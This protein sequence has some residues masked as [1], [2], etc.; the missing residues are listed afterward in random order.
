MIQDLICETFGVFYCVNYRSRLL[1]NM[2]FSYQKAKFVS[3]YLD[4]K[5]R[6]E[7]LEH[8]WP[9]IRKLAREKDSLV[10]FV[11]EALFPN[12]VLSPIHGL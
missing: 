6:K 5:A 7:W 3:D 8:T 11:D 12:G 9:E 10:L 1:K 2:D 4:E